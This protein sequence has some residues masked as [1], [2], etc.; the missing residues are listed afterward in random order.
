MHKLSFSLAPVRRIF[1]LSIM[2]YA[3]AEGHT[4]GAYCE[5]YAQGY[6]DG[7]CEGYS[8]DACPPSPP[9]GCMTSRDDPRGAY[10]RG[11][12]Q[13]AEDADYEVAPEEAW[14]E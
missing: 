2:L 1:A 10:E 4:Q 6:A 13:G 14:E 12:H 8:L 5:E 3:A 9:A 7:W 11:Y